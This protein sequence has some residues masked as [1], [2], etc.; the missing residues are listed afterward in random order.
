MTACPYC[1]STARQVRSGGNPSG[2][3]RYLCQA[4]ARKYTPEPNSCGYAP[5]LRKQAVLLCLDGQSFRSIAVQLGVNHQTVANWV[6][7][8][9]AKS[10]RAIYKLPR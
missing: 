3:Q 9:I 7:D 10:A 6:D 4:C 5:E 2:S 1:Q 8:Y